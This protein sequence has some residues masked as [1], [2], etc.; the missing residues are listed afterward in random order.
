MHL[1]FASV[2]L[3]LHDARRLF[4][5]FILNHPAPANLAYEPPFQAGWP[6][7]VRW[8]VKAVLVLYMLI[9]PF[10]SGWTRAEAIRRTP[11]S[12]PLTAGVYDVQRYVLNG[13]TVPPL[14]A[15]SVRWRDVIIDNQSGGSVGTTDSVFWQ[16]YRRG[17][18]RY[19]AD[20]AGHTIAVWKTSTALD[21]TWLFSMR[22]EIPDSTTIRFWT[23][24]RSDSLFVELVRTNRH[25]QLAERQF[26]WLSEYNR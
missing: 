19:R 1:F 16:R 13:V 20:T 26:H 2:F 22:Y 7:Y 5:L 17:Y 10:Q 23:K 6:R 3:L 25:F 12:R 8:G 18:F 9:L 11:P 4:S 14:L 21:S 24:I 15:D